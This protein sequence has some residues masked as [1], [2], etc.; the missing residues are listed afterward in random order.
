MQRYR[1]A[2]RPSRGACAPQQRCLAMKAVHQLR[3]GRTQWRQSPRG[4]VSTRS[5][6]RDGLSNLTS[7]GCGMERCWTEGMTSRRSTARTTGRAHRSGLR[8][9]P[10]KRTARP[11]EALDCAVAE[12]VSLAQGPLLLT[13]AVI[14]R[15]HWLLATGEHAGERDCSSAAVSGKRPPGEGGRGGDQTEEDESCRELQGRCVVVVGLSREERSR[16]SQLN[17]SAPAL[18]LLAAV[19][20]FPASCGNLHPPPSSHAHPGKERGAQRLSIVA[21]LA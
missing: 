20:T 5:G 4:R 7:C 8:R 16:S 2:T 19:S 18:S 3:Q 9:A 21:G 15:T 13:L 1:G 6:G 11:W 14:T 10:G 17:V 12:C